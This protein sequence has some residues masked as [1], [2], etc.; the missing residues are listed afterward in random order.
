VDPTKRYTW[1]EIHCAFGKDY[2]RGLESLPHDTDAGTLRYG[3]L[4]IVIAQSDGIDPCGTSK[5]LLAP[6][7]KSTRSTTLSRGHGEEVGTPHEIRNGTVTVVSSMHD[8]VIAEA[9][10]T[11]YPNPLMVIG[12]GYKA[13]SPISCRSLHPRGDCLPRR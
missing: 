9:S 2:S 6:P 7:Q 3:L 12:V 10:P 4:I 5:L 11:P 13:S 1:P 8:M